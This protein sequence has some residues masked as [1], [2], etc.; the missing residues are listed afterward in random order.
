M[1]GTPQAVFS[2]QFSVFSVQVPIVTCQVNATAS[3]NAEHRTLFWRRF[4][5]RGRIIQFARHSL[6]LDR[7]DGAGWLCVERHVLVFCRIENQVEGL[8]LHDLSS[9][10]LE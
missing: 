6:G 7:G 10:G 5:R 8:A 4:W 9:K 1:A 3:L 2:V